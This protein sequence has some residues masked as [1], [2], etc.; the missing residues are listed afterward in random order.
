MRKLLFYS[1]LLVLI[2]QTSCVKHKQLLNFRDQSEFVPLENHVIDNLVRIKIQPDDLLFITIKSVN[3]T[4]SA[5]FNLTSGTGNNNI[6]AG[7]AQIQGYLVDI[8][9]F[10]DFPV[11]GNIN[12]QGLTIIEAREKLKSMLIPKHLKDAVVN[13]R[14]LNFKVS[15]IGEIGGAR[16]ITLQGERFTILDALAQAGDLTAYSN[17]KN[18]LVIREQNGIREFGYVDI[19]SPDIF[20]SPYF[21]LHQNDIVYV[22]PTKA[23][24]ATVRDPISE[25]LPIISGVISL[26]A[27]IIAL[28]TR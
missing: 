16:S 13:I 17:R 3:E 12:L 5:P 21:Y 19:Q 14:F 24:T 22:E 7:N 27:L 18:I 15:V 6:N 25:T 26:G 8:D 4:A 10:I 11:L 20:H 28:V 1:I 2:F 23:V 9:G